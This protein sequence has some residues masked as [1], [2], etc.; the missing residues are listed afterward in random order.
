MTT[1]ILKQPARLIHT[2]NGRKVFA[3]SCGQDVCSDKVFQG[4]LIHFKN[5][6]KVFGVASECLN[7]VEVFNNIQRVKV[8]CNEPYGISSILVLRLY[9]GSNF[10]CVPTPCPVI[11]LTYDQA[12]D[13]WI[14]TWHLISGDMTVEF[15]C[16][17]GV[18]TLTFSGPCFDTTSYTVLK[19]C[20]YPFTGGGGIEVILNPDC[21]QGIVTTETEILYS[22]HSAT[23]NRYV[24]RLAN[25]RGG[26]KVFATA[27]C[28]PPQGTCT[29]G[30][31]CCGCDVSPVQWS[32]SMAGV[33]AGA[34][35]SCCSG[36]NGHWIL[37]YTGTVAVPCAWTVV[38]HAGVCTPGSPYTLT[39]DATNGVWRLT[40]SSPA[41]GAAKWEI[42]V[43]SWDCLGPNTLTLVDPAEAC[44]GWPDSVTI[45]P[46]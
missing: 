38:G 33:G 4:R 20:S 36:Y 22:I 30:A 5:G 25:V 16:T 26:I 10:N 15:T 14:G 37:T 46:V 35:G 2:R 21:C 7:L 31:D 11:P 6:M 1:S 3:F 42:S 24:A 9:V 8:N 39:C 19:S 45:T 43:A 27:I 32:F 17:A 40:T 28:C 34:A 13:K 41:G 23:P 29:T 44:I 12:Q 18:Y